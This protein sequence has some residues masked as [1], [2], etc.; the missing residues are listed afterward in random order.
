M[1]PPR[2][3]VAILSMTVH[4]MKKGISNGIWI[5]VEPISGVIV[6]FWGSTV[7]GDDLGDEEW[8]TVERY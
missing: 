1:Y 2:V 4:S 6:G 8:A 7:V 5:T 3:L